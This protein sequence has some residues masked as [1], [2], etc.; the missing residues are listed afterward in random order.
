MQ[1]YAVQVSAPAPSKSGQQLFLA[2]SE[3]LEDVLLSHLSAV[4]LYRLSMGCKGLQSWLLSLPPTV[5]L[6][7]LLHCLQHQS[8]LNDP[9]ML[10]GA[11]HVLCVAG[12]SL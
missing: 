1:S 10:H 3:V 2:S 12:P 11:E 5:W 7:K 8:A 4:D 9:S 6:V